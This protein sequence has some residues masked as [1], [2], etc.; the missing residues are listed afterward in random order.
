MSH[1]TREFGSRIKN[2]EDEKNKNL[3]KIYGISEII[4]KDTLDSVYKNFTRVA[5]KSSVFK[6]LN[7]EEK[8]KLEEC[9]TLKGILLDT[10]RENVFRYKPGDSTLRIDLRS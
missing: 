3:Q 5:F 10:A 1:L 2:I 4:C 6:R 8:F 7:A 9:I